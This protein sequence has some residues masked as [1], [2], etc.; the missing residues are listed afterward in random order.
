MI[1]SAAII[2]DVIG[3]VVLSLVLSMRDPSNKVSTVLIHTVLFFAVAAIGGFIMYHV[4]KWMDQRYP[5]T[6]R[7]PIIS[8]AYC[9]ALSYIAE[10]YFGIADITGAFIAGITI[11]SI[12]DAP[13]VEQKVDINTYIIFGPIFFASIGLKTNFSDMD[14]KLLLFSVCF[15]VIALL[16][17]IIGCG[18]V[19]KLSGHSWSDALKVGVGMMTRGEVAL[20]VTQ[21]GL[22][23]GV[24]SADYFTAVIL[25]IIISSVLT[26]ILLKLLYA[27]DDGKVRQTA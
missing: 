23:S 4:F 10:R 9:F 24:I 8:I 21:K 19:A 12:Q 14:A 22:S 2:D 17:K 16:G 11:C 20:I 5:H 18:A 3:I 7:I 27:K 13:Y 25:L 26:P 15:V 1:V 6:R